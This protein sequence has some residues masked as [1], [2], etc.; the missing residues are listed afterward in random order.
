MRRFLDRVSDDDIACLH[1]AVV[2]LTA[3]REPAHS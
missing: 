1:D 2:D 3:R